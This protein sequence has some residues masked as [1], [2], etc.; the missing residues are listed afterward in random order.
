[1]K[2]RYEKP[3]KPLTHDLSHPCKS[4]FFHDT[5]TIL[6]TANCLAGSNSHILR[7]T[8][9]CGGGVLSLIFPDLTHLPVLTIIFFTSIDPDPLNAQAHG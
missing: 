4:C 9:F 2:L 3:S 6:P 7:G 1:M 5:Y 8:Y